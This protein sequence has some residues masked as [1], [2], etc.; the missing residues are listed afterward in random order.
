MS[1]TRKMLKAMGIEEEKI[2]Q[3]IDAHTETVEGLKAELAT[4]KEKADKFD[5]V[6]KELDE[7][8]QADGGYKDKY[9]KEREAFE[10]Y[11]SE[12]TAKEEKAAKESAVRKYFEAHGITGKNLDIAIRGCKDE[13]ATITLADGSISDTTVLDNLVAGDYA[14]LVVS[15]TTQGASTTMPPTN[16]GGNAMT[17]EEILQIKDTGARQRAIAEN[18]N[19]FK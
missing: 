3:I 8:K 12:V 19:L 17:K 5:S 2:E 4:A 1:L 16:T 13:I 7:I 14:G 11:K 18:I 15:K 9:D 6:Q 10:A